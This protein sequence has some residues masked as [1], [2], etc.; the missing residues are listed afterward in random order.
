[1]TI[2]LRLFSLASFS[3]AMCRHV[4]CL[5]LPQIWQLAKRSVTNSITPDYFKYADDYEE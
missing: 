4:G 3:E 5:K 2:N 1:M